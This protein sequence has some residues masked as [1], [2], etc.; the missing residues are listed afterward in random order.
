MCI[1]QVPYFGPVFGELFYS[2]PV[3]VL[4]LLLLLMMSGVA[5][6]DVD[7]VAVSIIYVLRFLIHV[8]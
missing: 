7:A 2:V 4:I 8:F 5:V 1:V 3:G 6:S